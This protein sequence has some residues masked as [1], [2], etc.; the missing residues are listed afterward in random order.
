MPE[1]GDKVKAEFVGV[2]TVNG[3][4]KL[5]NG[6]EVLLDGATLSVLEYASTLYPGQVWKRNTDEVVF[7][8]TQEGTTR[9]AGPA[10]KNLPDA[11]IPEQAFDRGRFTLVYD[12]RN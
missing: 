3:T 7:T 12:P 6:T 10:N 8:V 1:V 11:P 9:V 5:T 2:W 4:V